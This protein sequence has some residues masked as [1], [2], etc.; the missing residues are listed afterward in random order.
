MTDNHYCKK[1]AINMKGIGTILLTSNVDGKRSRFFGRSDL[2]KLRIHA[3]KLLYCIK[4]ISLHIIPGRTAI[5]RIPKSL[6]HGDISEPT[7]STNILI[8][9]KSGTWLL[10][11]LDAILAP[12]YL[13]KK[14]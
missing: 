7:G 5:K 10:E 8:A 6:K 11:A 1:G 2:K 4:A 14:I 12:R 3:K 9:I 13:R